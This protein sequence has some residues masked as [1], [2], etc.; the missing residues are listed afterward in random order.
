M[1]SGRIRGDLICNKEDRPS[2]KR[3]VGKEV[4]GI[5]RPLTDESESEIREVL[6]GAQKDITGFLGQ[7]R[8]ESA[9]VMIADDMGVTFVQRTHVRRALNLGLVARGFELGRLVERFEHQR[10]TQP[11][12]L[13]VPF[14]D[15]AWFGNRWSGGRYAGRKLVGRLAVSEATSTLMDQSELVEDVLGAVHAAELNVERPDHVSFLR[16]GRSGDL[17]DLGAAHR[18]GV[19]D[20]VEDHFR[21]A[22]VTTLTLGELVVGNSY[23]QPFVPANG[24]PH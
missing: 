10:D 9:E 20:I 8:K 14:G 4:F 17:L 15:F 11:D 19:L 13:E 16:Y 24:I 22:G 6:R 21:A 3:R 18:N 5:Y 12:S 23:S 2:Y 1:R 7:T